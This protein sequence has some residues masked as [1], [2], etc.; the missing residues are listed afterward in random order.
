MDY[1]RVRAR[2]DSGRGFRIRHEHPDLVYLLVKPDPSVR[3]HR[4][5]ELAKLLSSFWSPQRTGFRVDGKTLVIVP[6]ERVSFR[7]VYQQGAASF[8]LVVPRRRLEVIKTKLESLWERITVDEVN[9]TPFLD[10][11]KTVGA[12]VHYLKHDMFS[13]ET[14]HRSNAPLESLIAPI[15]EFKDNDT[16]IVDVLLEPTNRLE[17]ERKSRRAFNQLRQGKM[18]MRLSAVNLGEQGFSLFNDLMNGIRYTMLE[19]TAFS[20]EQESAVKKQKR[21]ETMD[22]HAFRV[23]REMRTET[24]QKQHGD[25]LK[26]SLRTLVQSDNQERREHILSNLTAAWHDIDGDN[27][28]TVS[29]ARNVKGLIYKVDDQKHSKPMMMSTH[30]A[31]KLLQLPGDELQRAYPQIQ[32]IR[33][34]EVTISDELFTDGPKITLGTVTEKG[35]SRVAGLPLTEYPGVRQKDVYDALC[36]Q[37]FAFGKV[38]VGKTDGVGAGQALD[39]IKAGYTAFLLDTA[40]GQVAKT[41]TDALP[42]DC[43]D[44]KLIYLDFRNVEYPI[45]LTYADVAASVVGRAHDAELAELQMST[46]LTSHMQEFINQQSTTGELTDR[47]RRYFVSAAKATQGRPLYIQLALTSPAYRAE[48]LQSELVQSQPDVV[49][50]LQALQER[51][52]NGSDSPIIDPILERLRMMERNPFLANVFLSDDITDDD[53]R[54][55]IDFRRYA[56]NPDGGYGYCVVIVCDKETFGT[57]GQELIC[58]TIQSKIFLSAYSRIDQDQSERKPF[59]SI[60]DEPH[61]FI[62]GGAARRLYSDAAVELRKYR[63]RTLMLAHSPKQLGDVWDAF[64]SG[65]AQIIAYKSENMNDYRQ[66]EQ[67]L[68]PFDAEYVYQHLPE[69][70]EAVCKIRLPSGKESPAFFCHMASPPKAVKDRAARREACASIFGRHWKEA[71]DSITTL[72]SGYLKRDDE[73]LAARATEVAERKQAERERKKAEREVYKTQQGPQ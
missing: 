58:S 1:R 31:G 73:W 2:G 64:S 70:W 21:M 16:A 53:G 71:R 68:S 48:L 72:R 52:E 24:K 55:L 63:C 66:I 5:E 4:I 65:G 35:V 50:D 26:V 40:D 56:D 49:A 61:R 37:T 29:R 57:E 14:D 46:R 60:A 13:V 7:I 11:Q 42:E 43:P 9:M 17:W 51:A 30:E 62:R 34:T 23:M 15:R 32:A 22:L 33:R 41:L 6:P 39:M 45:P 28:L 47:M 19:L 54:P 67:Q 20:K 3:N 10:P 27:E 36:T 8:H 18:P 69:K 59:I 12:Y 38:G 25:V 44:E